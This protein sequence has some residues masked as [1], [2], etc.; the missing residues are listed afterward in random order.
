MYKK[1]VILIS[2]ALFFLTLCFLKHYFSVFYFQNDLNRIAL[3]VESDYVGDMF[4]C[5]NKT[6]QKAEFKNNVYTYE[7]KQTNPL[8]YNQTVKQP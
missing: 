1:I 5:F 2:L 8:F 7:L 4:F 3:N 6:C